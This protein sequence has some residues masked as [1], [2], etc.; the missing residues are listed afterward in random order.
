MTTLRTALAVVLT[1]LA[2]LA[3]ANT[4]QAAI[5]APAVTDDYLFSKSL[6]QFSSIRSGSPYADQLDWSSDGCSWSPDNPFGFKF[7]PACHRHDF[8][9]RNYKRQARFNETSR[10][11]IDDNFKSDLYHQ[12]AGNWACN[13]TADLYYEAV[14]KFGAS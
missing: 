5:N 2:L 6:A 10:L 13:R 14:R 4:A 3:G 8:G 7:L 9:Y 11:R 1:S 12:C